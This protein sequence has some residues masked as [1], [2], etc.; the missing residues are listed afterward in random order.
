MPYDRDREQLIAL[1]RRYSVR[2][3][4]FVLASGQRSTSFARSSEPTE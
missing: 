2:F 1:L 3:G 4:D